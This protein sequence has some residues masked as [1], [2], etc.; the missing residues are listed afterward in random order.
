[1]MAPSCGGPGSEWMGPGSAGEVHQAVGSAWRTGGPR[2]GHGR[3]LTGSPFLLTQGKQLK[4]I[5]QKPE[6]WPR[7]V[8]VQQIPV[9]K[10]RKE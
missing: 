6:N 5:F 9:Q 7:H 1:M 3:T 10:I 4:L 2:A 8:E